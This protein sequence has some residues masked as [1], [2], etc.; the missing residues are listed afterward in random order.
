[1]IEILDTRFFIEFF[2]S[3]DISIRRKTSN[4]IRE[5]HLR[6][7]G[8]LP[9]IVLAEVVKFTC[10][11]LGKEMAESR[12]EAI[13]Q[14]GLK[15]QAMTQEISKTA[16]LLK[17]TYRNVSMGDCIIAGTAIFA[18]GRV[19]SDDLHFDVIKEVKRIWI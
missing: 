7:E 3:S 12:Y 19:V 13:T 5:V 9:T 10:D 1:L 17:S 4:K 8:I 14:S 11:R 6:Q 18:H 15:I 2:Y 16:G